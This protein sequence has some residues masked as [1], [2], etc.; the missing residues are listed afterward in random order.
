MTRRF[1]IF[2]GSRADWGLLSMLARRLAA[3]PAAS[4]TVIATGQHIGPRGTLAAVAEDGPWP[5]RTVDMGLEGD[6]RAQISTAMGRLQ[7]GLTPL[8]EEIAPDLLVILGDRY[9]ALTA[10][11]AATVLAIP[12][13]HIAGGDITE[14][15]FDDAIR[16]AITKLS[17][18]HFVTNADAR[19]RLIAMGEDPAQVILSGSPGI[20]RL[21][22]EPAM[23]REAFFA[24]V[25]L[26]PRRHNVVATF[27]PVT[28]SATSM[29]QLVAMLDAL[30]TFSDELGIIF[31]GVNADPGYAAADQA[32]TA[33]CAAR[34]NA[35]Q[36]GTL[37]SHVYANA[38]RHCDAVIGNSSSGLYE[39][40]TFAIPTVNIGDRQQGRLR[41]SS[42]I[43]APGEAPA[44]VAA[45]R[46]ALSMDCAGT[47]NPYGDGQASRRI[48][49]AIMA[50][51][52][53]RQ[54][55]RKRFHER[56]GA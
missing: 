13:A 3:D 49:E 27:H 50:V 1:A 16:H 40:P 4:V 24:R 7:I 14:G 28:L 6:N 51:P 5:V 56:A 10:A 33:F 8:L 52:D 35:V 32:I 2:T 44:I 45:I 31:T 12:I 48:A 19:R 17:H 18:L 36:H 38:L 54:L 11:T 37:G 9:E 25:G 29:S 39:A 21:F 42:V 15:A 22:A 53:P 26:V 34:G 47:V 55:L 46:R 30:A 41:A 43:D 23:T 20:D